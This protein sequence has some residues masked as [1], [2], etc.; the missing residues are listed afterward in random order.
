MN[1]FKK[2]VIAA[3]LTAILFC[4]CV[5][6]LH[7]GQK[8]H[9]RLDLDMDAEFP[10][11]GS[12]VPGEIFATTMASL[13]EHELAGTFGWRPN[14][15]LPWGPRILADN[16][17]NRQ[18]GIIQAIRETARSFKDELTKISSA[19]YDP[20]LVQAETMF[21]NDATKFWF[22][23]SEDR[24]EDGAKYLRKYVEG[25]RSPSGGSRPINK[26]NVE[27]IKLFRVWSVLLGDA[28]A[29]LYRDR[30]EDGRRLRC[31]ETDDAFYRSQ[32]YTHAIY[33]MMLSLRRE[34]SQELADREVLYSLF[35]EVLQALGKAASLKPLIVLNGR[36]ACILANHRSN[37]DV[38]VTESWSKMESI[39]EELEK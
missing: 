36:P 5:G 35:D 14:D 13:I 31:W 20:N 32:G 11:A 10:G 7:F 24:F 12:I 27:L 39:M 2:V 19:D 8:G 28:H 3:C 26:R 23:S 15:L 4:A 38:F 18:L 17:A 30:R 34:Y 33:N 21:R 9:N 1:M 37:L 29:S 6:A 25:L 22:P 16:N